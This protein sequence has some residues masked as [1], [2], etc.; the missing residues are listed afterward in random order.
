MRRSSVQP[1][2]S[3]LRGA[4]LV[5]AS[6]GVAATANA[7]PLLSASG[8]VAPQFVVYS[9]KQPIDKKISEFALPFAVVVPVMSRL[10]IDVATAFASSKVETGN[11]S[12]SV[13]GL[14]DTQLR[15]NYT[16]GND[17]VVLTVGLNIPTGKSTVNASEQDAASAIAS[18]FL[19]FPVPS[20]GTGLAAT[21]GVAF[22]RSVRDW[23][24][25]LGA[26]MR[27]SSAYEPFEATSGNPTV[28]FQPGNEYRARLGMDRAVGSGRLAFGL[29]YSTFG[30]DQAGQFSYNTGDR[31]IPQVTYVRSLG[32]GDFVIALWD[33]YRGKG[34][35]LD[36]IDVASENVA[37]LAA[38]ISLPAAGF[39]FEPNIELRNHTAEGDRLGTLGILGLRARRNVGFVTVVPAIGVALGGVQY[40]KAT[41][42]GTTTTTSTENVSL[43]GLRAALTIRYVP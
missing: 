17:A 36:S 4:L 39:V 12:S 18:D 33:L 10:N 30:S 27:Q 7:Q 42:T 29:T 43:S 35:Q 40:T 22:A 31:L 13:S 28:R 16:F 24:I 34:K 11:K 37:N 20:L 41:T 32:R 23:N 15:A 26:S 6:A 9:F 2:R 14:T 3:L 21:G 38:S 25:G 5:A 19:V 8:R 1:V